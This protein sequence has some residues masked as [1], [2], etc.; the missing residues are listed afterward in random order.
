MRL[1]VLAPAV[2]QFGEAIGDDGAKRD[3]LKETS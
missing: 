2:N 1:P 3:K